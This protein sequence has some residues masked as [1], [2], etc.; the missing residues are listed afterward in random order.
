MGASSELPPWSAGVPPAG[1]LGLV[2]S[3]RPLS[4]AASHPELTTLRPQALPGFCSDGWNLQA[5]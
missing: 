2:P 5:C 4:L 1:P 3:S